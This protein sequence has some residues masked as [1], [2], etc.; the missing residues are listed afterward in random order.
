M[1]QAVSTT[2]HPFNGMDC[3]PNETDCGA[4]D[5]DYITDEK[6]TNVN[7]KTEYTD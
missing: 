2:M 1:T 5:N 3:I 6:N 4:D 7:E